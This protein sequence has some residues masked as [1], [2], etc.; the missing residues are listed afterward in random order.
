[1]RPAIHAFAPDIICGFGL[2]TGNAQ[3]A[4]HQSV[5]AV[6]AVQGIMSEVSPYM[7]VG[8]LRAFI[9]SRLENHNLRKAAGV[10]VENG[11]AEKWVLSCNS[12]ANVRAIPHA[13]CPEFFEVRADH[14]SREILC[15]SLCE[16]K[17]TDVVLRAFA[18]VKS[19]GARLAV[20]GADL[21][22][23][24]HR[25]LADQLGMTDRTDF[26]GRLSRADI[27]K[28]MR[29]AKMLVL[30]SRMDTSP[31]VI[32][33]AHA[34]G[35]PVVATRVGGI[36]EMIEDGVNGFLVDSGDYRA[37]AQKMDT[38]IDNP[39]LCRSMGEKGRESVRKRND[40]DNVAQ[41][42]VRFF[43][44]ILRKHSGMRDGAEACEQREVR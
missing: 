28:H 20:I 34:A 32:T 15:G 14:S 13:V 26:L 44:K 19:P 35:L 3:I 17:G 21:S 1:M 5:P 40:P 36:P 8:L 6:V 16:H 37:M 24:A 38:L 22:S 29:S 18:E 4:V 11:Y 9:H 23:Q 33:E 25:K 30:G 39:D 31:N 27:V 2:E 41:A 7:P 10:I 42:Y 12:K 43:E